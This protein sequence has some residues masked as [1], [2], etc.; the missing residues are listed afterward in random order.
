[1]DF[2]RE[3][4]ILEVCNPEEAK[5]VLT[6]SPY[7]GYFLPCKI[8]IY[9]DNGNTLIGLPKPTVLMELLGNE[10]LKAIAVDIENRLI[11]CIDQS[12]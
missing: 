1:M 2:E 5:R 12:K 7:V 6:E 8:V 3:Y 11:K 10:K 9:E 4:H